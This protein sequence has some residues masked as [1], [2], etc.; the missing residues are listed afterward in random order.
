MATLESWRSLP[1]P[2]DGE[3]SQLLAGTA[4]DLA[5]KRRRRGEDADVS[6]YQHGV[7]VSDHGEKTQW[8][9]YWEVRERKLKEQPVDAV[10]YG[11]VARHLSGGSSSSGAAVP[12]DGAGADEAVQPGI[13][14]GC[15]LIFNGRVDVPAANLG[16][17]LSSYQLSKLAKLHGADITP[18]LLK[19][20]VTHVICRQ[21]SGSKEVK[22]L[23]SIT[24]RGAVGLY[25]VK[26]EW[27]TDSI[28]AGRR[29]PER[30]YS[31]LAGVARDAG[32]PALALKAGPAEPEAAARCKADIGDAAGKEAAAGFK[33]DFGD[34]AGKAAAA[35]AHCPSP[36]RAGRGAPRSPSTGPALVDLL[37][38]MS[39]GAESSSPRRPRLGLGLGL[40]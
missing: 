30:G 37:S 22:A 12:W 36:L 21:L 5:F 23:E 7:T 25:F 34:A 32:L 24:S 26:P 1:Q 11:A 38:Q 28:A 13:F 10:L 33:A 35:A 27:I 16:A 31:L 20:R 39:Q 29:L 3:N 4:E 9:G 17:S 2:K 6:A 14:G 19:R 18:R 40:D 8:P 15:R